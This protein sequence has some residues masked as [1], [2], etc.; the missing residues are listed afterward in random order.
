MTEDERLDLL[1]PV[2][3]ARAAEIMT[4]RGIP[5][6]ARTIQRYIAEGELAAMPTPG[7]HARIKRSVLERFLRERR[8]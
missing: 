7:G 1:D 3:P 2:S 8:Q 4:A 6:T 5:T